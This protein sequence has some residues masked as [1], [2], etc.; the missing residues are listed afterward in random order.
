[1]NNSTHLLLALA[2]LPV[3]AT[4]DAVQKILG[5][6]FELLLADLLAFQTQ[7]CSPTAPLD[8]EHRLAEQLRDVG[9][10]RL[11]WLYNR[12]EGDDPRALSSPL[13]VEGEDYRIVRKKT[14][15]AVDTLFGP[16]RLRRHLDRP[17][18]RDSAEGSIVPLERSLGV[19]AGTSPALA[20]AAARYAAEAG[21]TQ[22]Q[23]QHQLRARHGVT[24]GTQRLRA[25]TAHVSGTMAEARQEFP[26]VRLLDLLGRADRSTG[27]TKPVLSVSRDG[28]S[29]RE[30]RHGLFEVATTGTVTVSDRRG[31]RLGT[32]YLALAPESG[33]H[34][35]TDQLTGLIEEVLQRW[36]GP[37]PRPAYVTDAGDHET[38]YFEQVLRPMI[39]P[40]TGDP[41]EWQRIIDFYHGM[42]RVWKLAGALC[43]SDTREGGSWARMMGRLLKKP[44][45]PFR[46]LHSAAAL[47]G[48]REL[49]RV[50]QKEYRK[51]YN[52]LRRRTG[53]MQ[54]HEY[55]R[56]QLPLG[57]GIVEAACKTI[58][59]QRLKLSGMSWKK[60]GAQVILD[61][62]VV[63]LSEVWDAAY[64]HTLTTY[65]Y[66]ALRT[67]GCEGEIPME[68]AA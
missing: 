7:A 31:Q 63:L 4:R 34:Q 49:N 2:T 37:R 22:R 67:P 27:R 8:L 32:V 29:L 23:V 25:L 38:K 14:P 57:S 11:E 13:R 3:A 61:L 16:I 36:E 5:R 42:E 53:W 54:Y 6:Q 60:T 12:L 68:M 1:M 51:A 65:R 48:R 35:M 10:E 40:R 21:A 26:V 18:S 46:V 52:Y 33:Q 41:L 30:D 58:Y 19:G 39:H 28:I 9:R 15:H 64:R 24:I 62:R 43:G 59:T 66:K 45:G 50:E 17:V 47:K 44:N 20:E 56:L 55:A